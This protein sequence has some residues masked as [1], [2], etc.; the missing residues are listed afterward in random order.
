MPTVQANVILPRYGCAIAVLTF[1][2][3]LTRVFCNLEKKSVQVMF[4]LN[5]TIHEKHFKL[6]LSNISS[7]KSNNKIMFPAFLFFC[8]QMAGKDSTKMQNLLFGGI[9]SIRKHIQ[10]IIKFNLQSIYMLPTLATSLNSTKLF[11]T[12]EAKFGN[13][14]INM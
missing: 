8:F 6:L 13:V 7:T 9:L 10:F 14:V 5:N 4:H 12:N 2:Q 1:T 11:S 3:I